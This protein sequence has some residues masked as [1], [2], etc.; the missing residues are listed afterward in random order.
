MLITEDTRN[1]IEKLYD[2][3]YKQGLVHAKL[4]IEAAKDIP[5]AIEE[6][7]KLIM[8]GAES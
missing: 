8:E 3:A 5:L 1:E 4:I 7:D 2:R 6:I